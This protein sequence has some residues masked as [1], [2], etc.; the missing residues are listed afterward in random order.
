MSDNETSE[1]TVMRTS[2]L[3]EMTSVEMVSVETA[4]VVAVH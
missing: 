4:P 1:R 3:I 2:P